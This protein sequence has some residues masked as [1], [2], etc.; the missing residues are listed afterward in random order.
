MKCEHCQRKDKLLELGAI[1]MNVAKY[2]I[3]NLTKENL[4]LIEKLNIS[5][6]NANKI[7]HGLNKTIEEKDGQLDYLKN[8]IKEAQEYQKTYFNRTN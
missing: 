7:I 5:T 4:L 3:E 2:K 8:S 1:G 6:R